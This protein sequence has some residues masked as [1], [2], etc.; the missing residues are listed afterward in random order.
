MTSLLKVLNPRTETEQ[1]QIHMWV[2][3]V[4][5]SES[6]SLGFTDLLKQNPYSLF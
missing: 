3:T 4:Y 2:Y 1:S 5:G 6:E